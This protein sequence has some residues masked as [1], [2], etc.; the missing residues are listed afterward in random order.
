MDKHGKGSRMG[1]INKKRYL[2]IKKSKVPIFKNAKE[3]RYFEKQE[4]EKNNGTKFVVYAE[5]NKRQYNLVSSGEYILSLPHGVQ[6]KNKAGSRGLFFYCADDD[7]SD[8]LTEALDS[9]DINWQYI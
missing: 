6:M 5:L 8:I 7:A 3:K 1:W 4:K 2:E 9:D